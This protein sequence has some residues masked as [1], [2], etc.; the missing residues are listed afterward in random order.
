M[1][2]IA[3]I[4]V[5]ILQMLYQVTPVKLY[6]TSQFTGIPAYSAKI[7]ISLIGLISTHVIS[8]F[9]CILNCS[10]TF[11]CSEIFQYK[12]CDRCSL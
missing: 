7:H 3:T 2:P 8:K 4:I 6:R 10:V 1:V 11:K 12:G 5:N 9:V